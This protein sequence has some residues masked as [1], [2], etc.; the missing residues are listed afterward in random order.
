MT[1]GQSGDSTKAL[2]MGNTGRNPLRNAARRKDEEVSS[3]GGTRG[4]CV[5]LF[6]CEYLQTRYL[7]QIHSKH[8][9][10]RD[11]NYVC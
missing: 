5:C 9:A 10:A 11:P 4:P 8:V 1:T 7:S 6:G 2:R 3:S